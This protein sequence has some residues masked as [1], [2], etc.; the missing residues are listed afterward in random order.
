MATFNTTK[1]LN[2]NPSL[3]P[4]IADRIVQQF[5]LEGFT[6]K[7]DSYSGDV[8]DISLAKGGAFKA[9]M[10]MKSALKVTMSPENGGINFKAGVGIFGQQAIP[11]AIT[12]LV[13]WPVIIT[14]VWGLVQQSKL[15]DK[16]L[17]IA[18]QVID[19]NIS[20][21]SFYQT[22]ATSSFCP[23]CGSKVTINANF[24]PNCGN[25]LI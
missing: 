9:I 13:F 14:Q 24:C 7:C 17:A 11:S 8:Y 6:A 25:N 21:A 15:D 5:Q 4:T 16:A 22:P 10:G 1:Y 3:I 2:G 19:E 23:N 12:L 18:E 20:A